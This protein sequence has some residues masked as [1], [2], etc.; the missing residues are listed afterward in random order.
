MKRQGWWRRNAVAL[1]ALAVLLP[2]T[3]IATGYNEWNGYFS[4]RPVL[5]ITVAAGEEEVVS[6]ET[7]GPAQIELVEDD[8]PR[9]TG[10]PSGARLVVATIEVPVGAECFAPMLREVDGLERE[11]NQARRVELNW[12]TSDGASGYCSAENVTSRLET[13]FVVPADATGPFEL[14]VS[15]PDELPRF[16]RFVVGD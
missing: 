1:I 9:A 8:D 6:G 7:W 16:L 5:P 4:G 2:A 10:V 11:W 15:I 13:P 3:V 12:H 14:D